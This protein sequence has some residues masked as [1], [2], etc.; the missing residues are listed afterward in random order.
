[1]SFKTSIQRVAKEEEKKLIEKRQA[2]QKIEA[3][4][5]RLKKAAE[6][7]KA[8]ASKEEKQRQLIIK[9]SLEI[10][11]K[12]IGLESAKILLEQKE[13][14]LRSD[15]IIKFS[16][17]EKI[18]ET[19]FREL[20]AGILPKR[21]EEKVAREYIETVRGLTEGKNWEQ[22]LRK[23]TKN[24]GPVVAANI[25]TKATKDAKI[26]VQYNYNKRMS[27]AAENYSIKRKRAMA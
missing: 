21:L 16:E 9:K 7:M 17:K 22:L 2:K 20:K 27:G 10:R 14:G 24:F 18:Q 3:K 11:G 13:K 1:M 19:K 26:I 5:I 12:E 23:L 25:I 4:E 8:L 6:A 15:V